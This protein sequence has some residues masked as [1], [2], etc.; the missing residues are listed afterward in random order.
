MV[1]KGGA[2]EN[3]F[4]HYKLL[5]QIHKNGFVDISSKEVKAV[6]RE[7]PRILAKIDCRED[8]PPIMRENKLAILAIKNG[9]YRIA[10]MDPFI[11]I[12]ENISTPIIEIEPPTDIICIDPF[13]INGESAALDLSAAS[14]ILDQVFGEPSQLSIRGRRFANL[15]FNLQDI[16]YEVNGVQI[17][18]DGGYETRSSINL[19]EAKIGYRSNIGI[20][21]LLYPQLYWAE[22]VKGRKKVNSFIFYLH[23]DVFRFIPY[24]CDESKG[25]ADHSKE[26]AFRFK[27]AKTAFS[28]FS[29]RENSRMVVNHFPFPQADNFDTVDGMIKLISEKGSVRKSDLA[30]LFDI[31]LRQVDYYT[32]VIKWL[33]LLEEDNDSMVYLTLKGKRIAKLSFHKRME[34][35]AQIIFSHPI[36]NRRLH[37]QPIADE[38][39][40]EEKM[41]GATIKRRMQT[42]DAWIK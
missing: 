14:G 38:L 15:L 30:S 5:E 21:Q 40:R 9:L 27:V 25:Y 13:D 23:N 1:G 35:L 20:R 4:E 6:D 19:I 31:V 33:G 18:V 42:V 36:F 24:I 28:L 39:F 11:E 7:E 17:E 29:I 26:Q 37:E 34:A 12:E 16:A 22:K 32:G 10:H 3:I 41:S 8:L 2:W